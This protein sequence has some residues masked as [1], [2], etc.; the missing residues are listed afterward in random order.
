M[1]ALQQS[2]TSL[3]KALRILA[4]DVA[5]DEL[6]AIPFRPVEPLPGHAL[7]RAVL[8]ALRTADC[9]LSLVALSQ[10]V[11]ARHGIKFVANSE[12]HRFVLR[13]R[14]TTAT[15]A[16]RGIIRQQGSLM[17]VPGYP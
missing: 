1:G 11:A 10:M 4:P 12:W 8:A 13:I 2:L 9:A 5:L 15:L 17:S 3:A 16:E 7:T 14:R 6:R